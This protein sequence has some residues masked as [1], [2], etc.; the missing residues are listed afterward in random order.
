MSSPYRTTSLLVSKESDGQITY[1]SREKSNVLSLGFLHVWPLHL[2]SF[3]STNSFL[4]C[5]FSPFFSF[6]FCF[7]FPF[8]HF[9]SHFLFSFGH[10]LSLFGATTHSVKRRKFPPHFLKSHVWPS[11]F[12]IYSLFLY[13]LFMISSTTWL[14][15]SNE[16][17]FPHMANCESFFQ[18]DNMAF[19]SVT[20]LG[21]HVASP[22][23]PC[24][25]RH[26]TPRKT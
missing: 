20:L 23:L 15:V 5:S 10:F 6:P 4:S 9:S 22:T 7:S 16:I 8:S 24:V 25:I 1:K 26:P 13:S 21:C 12:H 3:L 2:H 17:H 18:V 19:P 11:I 14:H